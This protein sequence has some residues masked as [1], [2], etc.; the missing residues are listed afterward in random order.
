M[1]R[2]SLVDDSTEMFGLH[3]PLD[4]GEESI[5][6]ATTGE[7]FLLVPESIL[8]SLSRYLSLR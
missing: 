4:H 8:I 7:R 5:S 6:H 2:Q 3:D 1:K